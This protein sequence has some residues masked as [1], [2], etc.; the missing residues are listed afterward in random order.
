MQRSVLPTPE[1]MSPLIA[2]LCYLQDNDMQLEATT[3]PSIDEVIQSDVVPPL[4]VFLMR[5]DFPQLYVNFA[6]FRAGENKQALVKLVT[7]ERTFGEHFIAFYQR[8]SLISLGKVA[9]QLALLSSSEIPIPGLEKQFTFSESELDFTNNVRDNATVARYKWFLHSSPIRIHYYSVTPISGRA[10]LVQWVDYVTR[11]YSVYKSWQHRVQAAQVSVVAFGNGKNSVQEHLPRYT[12]MFH[13]KII[14][15]LK[16]KGIRRVISRK[17]RPHELQHNEQQ[18]P[19]TPIYRDHVALQDPNVKKEKLRARAKGIRTLGRI[20]QV[21]T[22]AASSDDH[23]RMRTQTLRVIAPLE[24]LKLDN[25][26]FCVQPEKA[27]MQAATPATK[28]ARRRPEAELTLESK[29]KKDLEWEVPRHT[30][31]E[32]HTNSICLEKEEQI[33]SLSSSK[34]GPEAK[35]PEFYLLQLEDEAAARAICLAAFVNT[36]LFVMS[37]LIRASRH[38]KTVQAAL[39]TG[40]LKGVAGSKFSEDHCGAVWK[41]L[42]HVLDSHFWNSFLRL[43]WAPFSS[44]VAYPN[45]PMLRKSRLSPKPL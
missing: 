41:H 15:A 5:E 35:A 8:K 16:E 25:E 1:G 24:W 26:L 14:P 42:D 17:D 22:P 23:K 33:T 2:C 38:E 6:Y 39:S 12:E 37:P 4:V 29:R 27:P 36:P 44:F 20:F 18:H 3:H 32:L 45:A 21:F 31:L 9:P 11:I 10:G 13:A 40:V 43:K 30:L 34:Q 28:N 19:F 7:C